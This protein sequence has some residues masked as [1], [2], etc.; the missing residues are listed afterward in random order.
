MASIMERIGLI[1]RSNVTELAER[2]EDPEKVINQTIADAMVTLTKLRQESG[3]VFEGE[4][5]A[6][7]QVEALS[8]QVTRRMP[9]QRS[10]VR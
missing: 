7:R 9:A 10:H 1:V 4:T 5:Q 8:R 3:E 2:M 6:L